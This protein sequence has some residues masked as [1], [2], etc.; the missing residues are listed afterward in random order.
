MSPTSFFMLQKVFL[1]YRELREASLGA[2]D[3]RSLH[4][5]EWL[6]FAKAVCVFSAMQSWCCIQAARPLADP[7]KC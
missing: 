1:H 5:P 6:P 7:A 2:S 3:P 4:R